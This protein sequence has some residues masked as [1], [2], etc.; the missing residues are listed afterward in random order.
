MFDAN[1]PDRFGRTVRG[2]LI[3]V[4]ALSIGL[5]ATREASACSVCQGDPNSNLVKGAEAGVLL[6][7]LITYGLLLGMT[8]L[9]VS[10]FVRQRRRLART[11]RMESE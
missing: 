10:W 3:F 4:V 5:A 6:M 8:A 11:G 9:C 7:V 2:A 1:R